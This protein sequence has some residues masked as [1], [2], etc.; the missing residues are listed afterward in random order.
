MRYSPQC[1][2]EEFSEVRGSKVDRLRVTLGH[3]GGATRGF[4]NHGRHA[5]RM[6]GEDSWQT[7]ATCYL[8]AS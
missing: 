6:R 8:G 3:R 2:E 1:V 5:G 7:V 4:V